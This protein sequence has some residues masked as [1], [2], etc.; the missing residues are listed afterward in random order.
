MRYLY[1][2]LC[3]D[4]NRHKRL[5]HVKRHPQDPVKFHAPRLPHC[6]FALSSASDL[7]IEL[8]LCQT[9]LAARGIES[10][11]VLR[12]LKRQENQILS[13]GPM[14]EG[15]FPNGGTGGGAR[16]GREGASRLC[17]I[18]PGGSSRPGDHVPTN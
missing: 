3:W 6:C 8:A 11:A 13:T 15:I 17:L 9:G 14:S 12:Q 2:S 4:G 5:L 18:W 1:I 16:G 10:N 7:M